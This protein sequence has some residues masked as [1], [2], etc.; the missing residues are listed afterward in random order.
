M[1]VRID[2]LHRY[3]NEAEIAK[4]DISDDFK[5]KKPLISMVY[6]KIFQRCNG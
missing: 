5:L 4:G 1:A 6:A 2:T 3:S